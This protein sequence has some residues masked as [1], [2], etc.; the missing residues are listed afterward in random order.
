MINQKEL[1]ELFT[2][3][4]ETGEFYWNKLN[5]GIKKN[6]KAGN[7]K[8]NGYI[9]ISIYKKRYLAH[10][11]AWMYVHGTFPRLFIDHINGN[12]ADNRIDNLREADKAQNAHNSKLSNAN[13]SG[14]K[15]VIF[16]KRY[17]TW[18]ADITYRGKSY[19][20][21]RFETK[22]EA[23]QVRDNFAIKLHGDYAKF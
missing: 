21:G 20:L 13:K 22:E 11:L 9:Q 17:G 19:Y 18:Q 14:A 8:G 10:R 1:K 5:S 3:H 7:D 2:Y 15:G 23:K 16:Y 4:P 6:L 12:K